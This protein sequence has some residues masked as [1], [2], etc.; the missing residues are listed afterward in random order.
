MIRRSTLIAGEILLGLIAALVIGLAIAWWRLSQG[1]VDLSFIRE[2]VQT[3]LSEARQGRPVH[4]ERVQ[5]AWSHSGGAVDVRAV[6]ITIQD[7]HGHV[8][9]HS[10]E[11]RLELGVL[12]LLIGRIS[13]ERAEFSGGAITLTRRLNGVTYVAFGPEGAPPDI[14]LPPAPENETLEHR[15]ART[16]DNL[17][18]AFRPVGGAGS[19]RQISVR[20][21]RLAIIDEKGGGRW[22]ADAA[23]FQLSRQGQT[24]EL[25]ADARLEGAHGLAPANLRIATDTRFQSAVVSFGTHNVRPRALFSDAALG[26]FAG[27][28]APMSA[29]I[30]ID[31]DRR[32]GVNRFEG[33]AV[34][35]RGT[36]DMAG[37][38]FS[39]DGGR[40]HGRYDVDSDELIV[41]QIAVAGARTQMRGEM[42]L[43]NVSAIMRAAPNQPAAFDVSLPALQLDVPGTFTQPLTLS[44]VQAVGAIDGA[45]RSINFTQLHA[46][47]GAARIN[48]AGRLYWGEAGADRAT[49]MGV[50]M[51]G[52]I[53]GPVDVT[54]V[55]QGWPM[56]LGHGIHDY[57]SHALYAGRV[58][59]VAVRLDIRPSDLAAPQF[60]D[61]AVDVR[62]N[63]NGGALRFINTM[64]PITDARGSG[65]LRGN[66]FDM[67][68]AQA[69]MN[70][71]A[72]TN[73]TISV[74]HFRH[75]EN[76]YTTIAA[77]A[78]G[79]ARNILEVLMQ[80]PI[81][82]R[83]K[84]PVDAA[85]ASGHGSVNIRL[86]RPSRSDVRFEDWRFTVDGGIRNFAGNM[87]TRRVA[88]S[89]GQLTVRG[90]QRAIVVSGPIRAG[91]SAID[92]VR[93][94]ENLAR[95]G[96]DSSEYQ[97]SGDFDAVDLRRLGYTI[98]QYA[99]GRVGVTVTGQGRGFDVEQARVDVDL[100]NAAVDSPFSFYTKPAGVGA[101]ARMNVQRQGDGSLLFSN[102]DARGGGLTAMG[103]VRVS[104]DGR[105]MEADVPRLLIEGRSDAHLSALRAN[106]G[107]LDV[108]VRGAVFDAAPF[109][110]ASSDETP[111]GDPADPATP[112]P[113]SVRANVVVDHLKMRGGATLDDA[114]VDVTALR[115]VL[116]SLVAE[117]HAP[118]NRAFSLALGPRPT[119]PQGHIRMRSDDAGFAARAL[120]SSENVVGGTASADGDW[121]PGPPTTA[122]FDVRMRNFQIVRLPAMARLLSSAGSLTG[123]VEMLNGEGI[124]FGALDAHMVY[125]NNQIRFTDGAMRGPSLGLTGSGSYDLRRDNLDINGVVAPSPVLNLSMLGN[126]PV[127]GDLLVSRRG[128]GLFGMTYSIDGHAREPRVGVNPVSALTP[129]ILR[130]IFE[131]VQ[132]DGGAHST[133]DRSAAVAPSAAG[134]A[135]VAPAAAAEASA[136]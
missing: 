125:A 58:T 40:I 105:I 118:Q 111:A 46:Q 130:R 82:L 94:T 91:A 69:R 26:P 8:L 22:S 71:I 24:L 92:N 115:G 68:I 95:H 44:N 86:Q 9:S 43:R 41:D 30:A 117:G 45:A 67:T 73:G 14:I 110:D 20:G 120:T 54:T 31:L 4:I 49:H 126:V 101:S 99:E 80:Q 32:S 1:P 123:M 28:D 77:H 27:L 103:R 104:R 102:I 63:V 16:L 87:S 21:A 35:G 25:T 6:G 113:E 97:I 119:D 112:P 60:R 93:W 48:L 62:F 47:T 38:R 134:G 70:N 135:A 29:N 42:H 109:M 53:D 114:R 108:N 72:L 61:E 66:R 11:A 75:S 7:G 76:D 52:G 128:E 136:N 36:A 124:G 96:N 17:A 3:Q 57:L 74:P 12:P 83:D 132:R 89:Q 18:A 23:N 13:V 122:Q 56:T 121:H 10:D 84:L 15:V 88:L 100:T 78:E 90:D 5:L 65:V 116:V 133:P 39:L 106:D 98:A 131:P 127:I 85:S 34:I 107:V 79:D 129:G 64:S 37:G 2:S 59:D 51:Q 55:M 33:D 50:Q 19:L 81:N